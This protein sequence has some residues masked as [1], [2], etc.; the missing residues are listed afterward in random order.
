MNIKYHNMYN[1]WLIAMTLMFNGK[2][3]EMFDYAKK[4]KA[5]DVRQLQNM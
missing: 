1:Q 5:L 2:Y 4:A 3:K